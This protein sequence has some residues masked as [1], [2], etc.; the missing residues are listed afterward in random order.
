MNGVVN[1]LDKEFDLTDIEKAKIK[2]SLDV[3][4]TDISKLIV[5]IAVF[6]IIGETRNFLYSVLALLFVRP[7][8]G[9]LHFRTYIGCFLFTFLF[10]FFAV[11]LNS[12]ISLDYYAVYMM[13]FSCITILCIAP[14]THKNRPS[15][16]EHKQRH[17]KFLALSVIIIHLMLYLIAMKN[18][19]LN[20]SIWV[21]TLQ[22]IQLLIKKGVDIYEKNK[23]KKTST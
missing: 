8:T 1:Y 12:M 19:Y 9:G 13:I 22:S 5:L 17:F 10:F 7:F 2:Y 21:I 6:Y 15:Y 4:F 3:L 16:S 11:I 18:P 14:I 23:L 20:I